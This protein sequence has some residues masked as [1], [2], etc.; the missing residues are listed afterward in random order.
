MDDATAREFGRTKI[1]NFPSTC[2]LVYACLFSEC[3]CGK[4]NV[5]VARII[6]KK[7]K[8]MCVWLTR[9]SVTRFEKTPPNRLLFQ[10]R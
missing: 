5:G 1:K 6:A 8:R 9:I 4:D 2:G 7:H 10:M 3:G